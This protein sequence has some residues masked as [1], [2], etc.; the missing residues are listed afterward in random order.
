[1]SGLD[2]FDPVADDPALNRTSESEVE[3][4]GDP[5]PAGVPDSIKSKMKLLESGKSSKW[6]V[7]KNVGAIAVGVG[8]ALLLASN[9]VG[10][11]ITGTLAAV[12]IGLI[13]GGAIATA[14]GTYMTVRA[15]WAK[16]DVEA[17]KQSVESGGPVKVTASK[18]T[19]GL[20][21]VANVLESVTF[22]LAG[23]LG[24]AGIGAAVAP[25][26]FHGLAGAGQTIH[27][28]RV[29]EYALPT[30]YGIG[31]AI[32]SLPGLFV[33]F[34][35]GR[36]DPA[37]KYQINITE[38]LEEFDGDRKLDIPKSAASYPFYKEGKEQARRSRQERSP[39]IVQGP[40][41]QHL[42]E[43]DN[44]N[45]NGHLA[46]GGQLPPRADNNTVRVDDRRVVELLGNQSRDWT[47][48]HVKSS[49]YATMPSEE[50]LFAGGPPKLEDLRQSHNRANCFLVAG[51][52]SALVRA[53]GWRKIEQ[54]MQD[55]HDGTVTVRLGQA[56]V[57]VDKT[58]IV[59]DQGYDAFDSGALWA[60]ILEKAI[61]AYAMETESGKYK[62]ADD[63]KFFDSYRYL[64]HLMGDAND[65]P[66]NVDGIADPLAYSGF[67][68]SS[69]R[70]DEWDGIIQ[71]SLT[72]GYP[73][74][75]QTEN[76]DYGDKLRKRILPGHNYSIIGT[77]T[78]NN[79]P[80]YLVFDPHS[81]SAGPYPDRNITDGTVTYG[82]AQHGNS[83]VFFVDADNAGDLFDNLTFHYLGQP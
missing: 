55:N 73:V 74:G 28:R 11:A 33:D 63:G 41:V 13:V 5:P 8:A 6:R 59:T 71:R 46:A 1:M 75:F 79:R 31:A 4:P 61:A 54:I 51:L 67:A 69:N 60:H 37:L 24:A 19:K 50:Q 52:A 18:K 29:S 56:D 78:R 15:G 45:I 30:I 80:G 25:S 77:A 38:G 40:L 65:D 34:R 43:T 35:R 17:F 26:A 82:H 39:V 53:G 27:S 16:A 7:A 10:W 21:L 47:N 72:N 83:P 62:A 20:L 64:S 9:P 22:A 44:P 49:G 48:K 12:G 32:V 81:I 23:Y 14:V 76:S 36:P 57:T 42:R 68:R 70:S 58:R 2:R 66:T 3:Q